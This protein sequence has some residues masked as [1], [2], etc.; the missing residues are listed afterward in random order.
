ME[1]EIN[2]D[3]NIEPNEE[4]IK[5]IIEIEKKARIMKL[6]EE[7][8]LKRQGGSGK[9]VLGKPA[10]YPEEGSYYAEEDYAMTPAEYTDFESMM[11]A[12]AAYSNPYE[13]MAPEDT[14]HKQVAD[15][16]YT[17]E[18]VYTTTAQQPSSSEATQVDIGLPWL[19]DKNIPAATRSYNLV[20]DLPKKGFLGLTGS[21]IL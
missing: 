10:Y 21:P 14:R 8:E 16:P 17:A 7:K 5:K 4:K 20:G 18:D 2:I 9:K 13:W 6:K 1:I 15:V 3:R 12:E 19:A 11:G